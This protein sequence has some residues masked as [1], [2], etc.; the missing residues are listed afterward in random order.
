MVFSTYNGPSMTDKAEY[1]E[2]VMKMTAKK[3]Y[4]EVLGV[5]RN[6]DENSIK[7][8]ILIQMREMPVLRKNLKRLRKLIPF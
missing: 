7:N 4:Y 5:E 8:T 2:E 3:D 1:L 6:A